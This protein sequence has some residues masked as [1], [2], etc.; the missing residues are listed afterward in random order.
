MVAALARAF[1]ATDAPLAQ[2]P[3]MRAILATLVLLVTASAAHAARTVY[4]NG[5]KLESNVVLKN[6][7]FSACTV[8]FDDNGD[9][10]IEAK[11]VKVALQDTQGQPVQPPQPAQPAQPPQQPQ[12]APVTKQYWLVSRESTS[13]ATQYDVEVWMNGQMVKKLHSGD[14]TVL[15]VT[16][17]VKPG[18]NRVRLVATKNMGDKRVSS[19]A[20]DTMEVIVGEGA[21]KD[22]MLVVD[23]P[24]VDS[25]RN[26]M[27][28]ANFNDE[29][30]FVSR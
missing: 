21:L 3:P 19:S 9:V 24:V 27:E 30:T 23:R 13:G 6:Q 25:R 26:A 20:A 11:G 10:W 29:S 1:V 5:V 14:A 15:D 17:Y 8:K 22:G 2:D 18:D 12:A 16:K 7:T 28:T 4:L